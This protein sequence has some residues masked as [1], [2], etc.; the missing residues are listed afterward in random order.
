[1]M[2]KNSFDQVQQLLNLLICEEEIYL[3][4]I[5]RLICLLVLICLN[6]PNFTTRIITLFKYL[7]RKVFS[8]RVKK[9][10]KKNSIE[11]LI[12]V[13]SNDLKE[14]GCDSL[15][16]VNYYSGHSKVLSKFSNLKK[17]GIMKLTYKSIKEFHLALQ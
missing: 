6:E 5:L 12:N 14:T 16:I 3:S 15:V 9:Y 11:Q 10:L 17:N 4:I 2:I 13:L 1:D 8:V 7:N